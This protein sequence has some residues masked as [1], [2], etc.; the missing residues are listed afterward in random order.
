MLCRFKGVKEAYNV[1]MIALLQDAHLQLCPS[2]LICL[3]LQGFLAHGL[4][5][6]QL[7][8]EFVHGEGYLTK[9]ALSQNASYSIELTSGWRCSIIV[10]EVH[11]DH[12][13]QLIEVF[14]EDC[15]LLLLIV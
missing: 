1:W 12:P 15:L 4:D 6:Y 13:L 11:P 3:A 8:T 5:C 7:L 9:G 2:A 14:D 10:L